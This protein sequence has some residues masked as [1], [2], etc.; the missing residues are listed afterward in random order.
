MKIGY[1]YLLK[2]SRCLVRFCKG[3]QR[4]YCRESHDPTSQWEKFGI[5]DTTFSDL[6]LKAQSLFPVFVMIN[7]GSCGTHFSP[8]GRTEV[9]MVFSAVSE[10]LTAFQLLY[11]N[12]ANSKDNLQ[13]AIGRSLPWGRTFH[14][15][16]S[17]KS[18]L[19]LCS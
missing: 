13:P 12:K 19:L 1:N 14:T 17:V 5:D 15:Q 2:T 16:H 10:V 3:N 7:S 18:P 8:S 9:L 4:K 11:W 6:L